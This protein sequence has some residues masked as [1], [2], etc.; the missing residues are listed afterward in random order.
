MTRGVL[1]LKVRSTL[2]LSTLYDLFTRVPSLSA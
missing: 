1:G 2:Q